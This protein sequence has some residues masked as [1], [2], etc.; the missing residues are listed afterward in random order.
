MEIRYLGHAS[1]EVV[2]EGSTLLFD[3]F[4][5]PNELAKN[6]DIT[7][8]QPDYILISHAH[9]DHIVDVEAIAQN[10]GAM[11]VSNYEIINWFQNKGIKNGHPMNHGGAVDFEFGTVKMVNAI[12]SSSFPDGSYGGNP[13]GFVI[14]FNNGKSIY[15]S[16]DTALHFDMKLIAE[17]TAI[18]LAILPVGDTYTMGYLD[19]IKAAEFVGTKKIMAA[20]YDTFPVIEIN[21]EKAKN[22]AKETNK[23]MIFL[24]IGQTLKL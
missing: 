3:P 21:Q 24:N 7:E 16:G 5:T 19:A 23:E 11:L 13:A 9:Q 18:D 22:A 8:L 4:I 6:I 15:F 17:E 2:Y 10:S 20:H 1:F 14:K 12:H